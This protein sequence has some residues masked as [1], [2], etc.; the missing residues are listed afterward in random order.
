MVS[1]NGVIASL[2]VTEF[3]ACGTGVR[4][5]NALLEAG[6]DDVVVV[7]PEELISRLAAV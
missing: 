2:A 1:L 6:L 5:P 3:M 4:R 7:R